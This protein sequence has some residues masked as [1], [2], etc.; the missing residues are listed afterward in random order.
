MTISI[1]TP[2]S[3]AATSALSPIDGDRVRPGDRQGSP[4]RFLPMVLL[5]RCR[6]GRADADLPHPQC[7]RVRPIRSAGRATR[8]ASRPTAST[9]GMTD[10]R[11]ADGVLEFDA[12]GDSD[13][14]LVRLFRALY[15]GAARR[16]GRAHRGAAG[17]RAPR[18]RPDARR[19]GDRLPR[20]SAAGPKQVWLYA[21]QHPG[22]SDGRMVDGGRAGTADRPGRSDRAALLRARRPSTSCPT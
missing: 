7:R 3:T 8:R 4:V 17:R 16:A 5:P 13:L 6:R 11:Y 1:I 2:P 21:R 18:A 12:C 14:A 10:T 15:D 20:R 19:A 9:G 22:E